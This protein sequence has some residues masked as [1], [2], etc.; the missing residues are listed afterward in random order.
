MISYN[1]YS[2]HKKEIT[3]ESAPQCLKCNLNFVKPAKITEEWI[4][5]EIN[6]RYGTVWKRT[7]K[8]QTVCKLFC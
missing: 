5:C 1:A 8:A 2:Y 4:I 7:A 6:A 3:K